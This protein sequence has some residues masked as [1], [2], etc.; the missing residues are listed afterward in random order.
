GEGRDAADPGGGPVGRV[1]PGVDRRGRGRSAEL[2][3]APA[4]G[5]GSPDRGDRPEAPGHDE[6]DRPV[7]AGHRRPGGL[8][9]A[10]PA[11][12]ASAALFLPARRKNP[13]ITSRT[14]VAGP[15]GCGGTVAA[16]VWSDRT[17]PS[18]SGPSGS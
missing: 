10:V 11:R 9:P 1:R 12:P 16:C 7:P 8:T 15:P 2:P 17:A 13:S 14:T 5:C 6:L 18:A 4:G 3:A